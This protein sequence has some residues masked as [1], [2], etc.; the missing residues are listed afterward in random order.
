MEITFNLGD[1]GTRGRDE[2]VRLG[3]AVG[4]RKESGPG[5]RRLPLRGTGRTQPRPHATPRRRVGGGEGVKGGDGSVAGAAKR[6]EWPNRRGVSSGPPGP[7]QMALTRLRHRQQSSGSGR[8]GHKGLWLLKAGFSK[9][10][11]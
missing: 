2:G 8:K 1:P 7:R 5:S 3:P 9:M 6:E 4:R 10:T 11:R